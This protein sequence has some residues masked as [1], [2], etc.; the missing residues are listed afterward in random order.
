MSSIEWH[1]E[2]I[3]DSFLLYCFFQNFLRVAGLVSVP[4]SICALLHRMPPKRFHYGWIRELFFTQFFMKLSGDQE[5]GCGIKREVKDGDNCIWINLSKVAWMIFFLERNYI[6]TRASETIK[7]EPWILPYGL[8]V[9][10]TKTERLK[11][12][13]DPLQG[14]WLKIL[15]NYCHQLSLHR[16]WDCF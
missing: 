16:S 7:S 10:K 4:L 8:G 5:N 1:L 2:W 9:K 6:T 14:K 3:R 15:K 11:K 13:W 12:D